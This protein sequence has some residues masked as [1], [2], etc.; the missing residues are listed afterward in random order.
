MDGSIRV[1][2]AEP[3]PPAPGSR[4]PVVGVC[5]G[6]Y[7]NGPHPA[8]YVTIAFDCQRE[9]TAHPGVPY[10]YNFFADPAIEPEF[11]EHSVHGR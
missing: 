10:Y 8:G 2:I 11:E 7:N 9:S 4:V 5:N 1:A 6:P 3:P